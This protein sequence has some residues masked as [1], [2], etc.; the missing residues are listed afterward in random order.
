MLQVK[1]LL[2]AIVALTIGLF[3]PKT[4]MADGAGV[5][6]ANCAACHAGGG[7][8]VNPERTLLQADLKSFLANYNSD[9]E[10]AIVAQVTNGAGPMPSF[11]DVLTPSEISE[12]AAYVESMSSKGW[13]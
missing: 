13:G 7:N 9:H 10:A 3:A 12:V 4:A 11:K 5:F 1:I 8:V 2:S 6:S